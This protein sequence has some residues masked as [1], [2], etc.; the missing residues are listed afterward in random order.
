MQLCI[1]GVCIPVDVLIPALLAWLYYMRN[2]F[3]S[4][5]PTAWQPKPGAA[6]AEADKSE[7]DAVAGTSSQACCK[8]HTLGPEP[9]QPLVEQEGGKDSS[10]S[11]TKKLRARR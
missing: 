1:C 5:L 6:Q 9:D 10:D 8:Q 3:V 2:Y 4:L 7:A 11:K